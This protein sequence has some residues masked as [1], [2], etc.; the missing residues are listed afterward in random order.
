MTSEILTLQHLQHPG[1]AKVRRVLQMVAA[2]CHHP[3]G[4]VVTSAAAGL[5][6]GSE[7]RQKTG[8]LR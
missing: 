3:P 6:C 8:G 2:P 1:A 4:R 7:V 5:E